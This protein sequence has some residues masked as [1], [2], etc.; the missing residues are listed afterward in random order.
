MTFLLPLGLAALLLLPIIALLHLI[1]QRRERLRVPSLQIW[2]DLQRQSVQQRPRR[3]PL[4]LLLLLHL[5]LTAL[6]AIALGQPF[7][8]ASRGPARHT[9]IVLDTSTSM[10]ATDEQPD[11]LTAAKAEAR[12][13]VAGLRS[14]DSAALIELTAQPRVLA[15]GAGSDTAALADQ[16]NRT[17]AGGP[18]GDLQSALNLAQATGKPNLD[19]QIVVLTDEALRGSQA[20]TV[21]GKIDWRTFGN[22]G[23]NVA[24]VAF[25]ARPLRNGQQ[26]LYARVTNL[27]STAIARTLQLDL[28]GTRAA[29]EPMRLAPGGEAEWS[30]PLPKG[31]KRATASLTGSDLQPLDDRASVV[32][33]DAVQTRV[34][35]VTAASTPLERALLAQRGFDVQVVAPGAYQPTMSADLVV[36]YATIPA[37]LPNAPMLIVAP[38]QN[39]SL[40]EVT[41]DEI[42]PGTPTINDE[43]FR[44]IDLKP[45][46]FD[47]IA[48]IKPPAWANVA[49]AGGT[50]PLVLTGQYNNQPMVIWSFDP[51]QSNIASRLAFP[52]LT[53]ATTRALLPQTNDQILIGSAA[54]FALRS[55]DGT[56]VAAGER[57]AK[58]GLYEAQSGTGTIAVNALDS[59]EADLRARQQPAITT[60][61]RP[62]SVDTTPV[63]R[64]L[65][66]WLALAGLLVL[67]GEW[68]YSNRAALRR[69]QRSRRK[70][71][72][73]A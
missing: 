43:R 13:I 65:W 16:L 28:D 41:G 2:R 42:T 12:R 18:D 15:Q 69:G 60:I 33:G 53:A 30:W 4:T 66:Y 44:T 63:G 22:A 57:I 59:A 29:S 61:V 47:R 45:V 11:R 32:I 20:A 8:Q 27:G 19:L 7:L 21:A 37:T 52:L 64:E 49:I 10:A 56:S 17:E 72:A 58:P 3:L 39:Q 14:G 70:H 5:L 51:A 68:L 71:G 62:V 38:P 40:L 54:P 55:A 25:A 67:V 26:Q 24:I 9:A 46:T 35:L 31:A 23:D 6:L 73:E 1:R 34:V 36:F 48:A 50:T